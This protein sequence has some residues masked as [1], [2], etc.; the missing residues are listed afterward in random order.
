MNQAQLQLSV[1]ARAEYLAVVRQALAGVA[2]A[3]EVDLAI[4]N[5]IKVAVN[6]ACTNVV[7]HAY[8]DGDGTLEVG[9]QSQPEEVAIIV[10][11]SGVGVQRRSEAGAGVG[12]MLISSLSDRFEIRGGSDSGIEV[13][14]AFRID[15]SPNGEMKAIEG[16]FATTPAVPPV[17]TGAVFSA[18][19]GPLVSP[20]ITRLIGALA[21]QADLSLD[22]LS[23]AQLVGEAISAHVHDHISGE[24]ICVAIGQADGRL[25]IRV[26]PL[27]EQGSDGLRRGFVLPGA[28]RSLEQLIDEVE[29]EYEQ[30]AGG[31]GS[32]LEFLR[33]QFA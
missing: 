32:R 13:R 16:E 25:E 31:T 30:A 28:D 17:S 21:T 22:R 11:D 4:L 23:D 26:G 9:V 33:L 2:D 18:V 29:V 1:P 5:D 10:R 15:S 3:L 8:P 24:R 19:P 6:E 27:V 12:F 20:V 7:V 14:M